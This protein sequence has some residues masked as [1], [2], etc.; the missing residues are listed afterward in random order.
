M[1]RSAFWIF[2]IVFLLVSGNAFAMGGP[3]LTMQNQLIGKAAPD[4]T[5]KTLAGQEISLNEFRDGKSAI[6]F[7]W[8]TWCPHCREAL[9]EI[10]KN[11]ADFEKKEIKLVLVDVGETAKEVRVHFTKHAIELNVFIDAESKV[12]D[13]YDIIGVPTFFFVN[14]SGIV[15][16]M[17]YHLPENYEEILAKP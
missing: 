16:G 17:E 12:S 7:F 11:I 6:I 15:T 14:A 13:S 2:V 10:N 3:I 8:A 5:L 4:F 9:A 1:K